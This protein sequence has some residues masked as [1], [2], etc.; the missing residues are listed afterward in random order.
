[1][2]GP[3]KAVRGQSIGW[4]SLHMR[5]GRM[6]FSGDPGQAYRAPNTSVRRSQLLSWRLL[7]WCGQQLTCSADEKKEVLYI[8]TFVDTLHSL[9]IT[10]TCLW[11]QIRQTSLEL[12]GL[13]SRMKRSFLWVFC[14]CTEIEDTYSQRGMLI[15]LDL[16]SQ[17]K[18]QQSFLTKTIV[19]HLVAVGCWYNIVLCPQVGCCNYIVHVEITVIILEHKNKK[20]HTVMYKQFHYYKH[21]HISDILAFNLVFLCMHALNAIFGDCANCFSCFY[22]FMQ[23]KKK[24]CKWGKKNKLYK[25]FLNKYSP[26]TSLNI[27]CNFALGKFT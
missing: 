21:W 25:M 2:L 7:E 10:N 5:C 9:W 26:K 1:M 18:T 3:H 13:V 24:C 14:I 19:I 17:T 4:P 15:T 16:V 22:A 6:W 23:T 27:I 11:A 12:Y 20:E 8:C